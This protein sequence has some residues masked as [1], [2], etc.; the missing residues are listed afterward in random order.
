MFCSL[1]W[2]FN[3]AGRGNQILISSCSEAKRTN[4]NLAARFRSCQE[5]SQAPGRGVRSHRQRRLVRV[6][7]KKPIN[8]G[9]ESAAQ[10]QGHQHP[11]GEGQI[12]QLLTSHLGP[13]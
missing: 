10:D 11:V 9:L 1:E 5:A 12:A 13:G 3:E 7:I 8:P 2:C 4:L 6:W